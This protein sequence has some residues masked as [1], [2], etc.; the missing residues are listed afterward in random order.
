[1]VLP[2]QIDLSQHNESRL[3]L[4]FPLLFFFLSPLL[5]PLS[6]LP[7]LLFSPSLSLSLPPSSLPLLCPLLLLPAPTVSS[8]KLGAQAE[9]EEEG[10]NYVSTDSFE[11]LQATVGQMQQEHERLIGTAAHLSHEQ[12]INTEHIKVRETLLSVLG[13]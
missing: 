12:E 2:Y 8:A 13:A 4:L 10:A 9:E 5:L 3:A 6:S 11:A 1:M 7:P